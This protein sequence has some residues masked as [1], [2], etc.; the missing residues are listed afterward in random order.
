M[1]NV[2]KWLVFDIECEF[3]YKPIIQK[4]KLIMIIVNS[5]I[6]RLL[7]MYWIENM[8]LK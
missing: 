6:G 2:I 8:P 7:M 5:F 1:Y 4:I 3:S